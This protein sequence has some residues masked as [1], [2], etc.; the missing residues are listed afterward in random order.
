MEK[1]L[2]GKSLDQL[3]EV[4]CQELGCI[5][6]DLEL[7]IL[8]FSSSSFLG[9]PGKKIRIKAK[10]KTDKVLSERANRA[11]MFLK[12]LLNYADLKI[13]VK[14]NILKD[15]MQVEI[16]LSGEDIKYLIQNGAEPLTALEFLTNKVVARALGVGPKIV[17]KLEGIDIEKEKKLVNAVR[18]AVEKI[19]T[20]K[21]PQIIKI[22]S[23]REQKIVV[24]II[25]QE[26]NID[27]KIEGE[28]KQKRVILNWKE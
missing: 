26:E 22:S 11:F 14:V 9:I 20:N 24:N 16:L 4:A 19:K 3:I 5:P 23:Q 27:Y 13:D 28:G 18:R 8:E 17:L 10:I 2:E 12:E 1:E 7:E 21:E 15:K 6:E 25:K